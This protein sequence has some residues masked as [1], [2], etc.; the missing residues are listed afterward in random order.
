[1]TKRLHLSIY[2]AGLPI[3]AEAKK[4]SNIILKLKCAAGI[5][6]SYTTEDR[7]LRRSFFFCFFT[8]NL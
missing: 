7:V 8:G 3:S 4:S 2:M 6:I 1:M 5:L